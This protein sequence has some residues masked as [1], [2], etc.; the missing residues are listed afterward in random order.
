MPAPHRLHRTA[1]HTVALIIDLPRAISM[2]PFSHESTFPGVRNVTHSST[3]YIVDVD[4]HDDGRAVLR[5]RSNP[6]VPRIAAAAARL[7]VSLPHLRDV[8]VREQAGPS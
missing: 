1:V 6:A 7:G 3:M 5:P 2:A 8:V 4:A